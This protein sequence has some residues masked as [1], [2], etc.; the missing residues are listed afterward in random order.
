MKY[1]EGE[2]KRINNALNEAFFYSLRF[3]E[4]RQE[5]FIGLQM[6]LCLPDGTI[7]NAVQTTLRLEGVT[8]IWVSY[9]S[10]DRHVEVDTIECV[11]DLIRHSGGAS[12]YGWEF[13]SRKPNLKQWL[14]KKSYKWSKR[15]RS[16]TNVIYLFHDGYDLGLE[17]CIDLFIWFESMS[18][19]AGESHLSSEEIV[20]AGCK[21][22]DEFFRN[23][24]ATKETQRPKLSE[25]GRIDW[26]GTTFGGPVK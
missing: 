2:V 25:D 20:T 18:F 1:T 26:I 5:C 13:V 16:G 17:H 11:A 3:A 6:S 15:K 8:R 22:W 19:T 7:N 14:G 9:E 21:W 4:G 10:K 24:L 23:N 12:L